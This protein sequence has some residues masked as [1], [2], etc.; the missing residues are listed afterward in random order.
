[1]SLGEGTEIGPFSFSILRI[2]IAAG[3]ARVIIRR[4]RIS[5]GLNVLDWLMMVW[6]GWVLASSIFHH[7]PSAALVFRL[8][9]VYNAFGIYFLLRVFCQSLDDVVGLCRVTAILLI[10]LAVEML[11]EQLT[12]NNLFS[13][14]GGVKETLS[15]RMGRSRAQGP[16]GHSILAGTV[17]AVSLPLMIGLWQ[18]RRKMAAAGIMACFVMVFTSLSSG[19]I[20]SALAA[21]GALLMWYYRHKMRLLRWFAVFG[22]IALDM[23]MEAKAYY[24]ISRINPAGGGG[25][26]RAR[27]IESAFKHLNEWWLAG[28]DYTR[29]WMPTGVPWTP[30][31]TDITNHYLKMGV[32]GGLPLMILYIAILAKGFSFVGQILR[33]PVSLPPK[34]QFLIWA[35]GA[36]LFAHTVTMIAVSYFDQSFIFMYLTIAAIGSAWSNLKINQKT[37]I[38]IGNED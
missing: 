2:L 30:D 1:M 24:I 19:P 13:G 26:H 11:Y 7:D 33:S 37:N 5:G 6:A 36:S 14:L 9:F 8:G 16:F 15:I 3:L 23:V 32:I 35:L 22:Y 31:H 27:L 29:H 4:E 10:P 38:K 28:T 12:G 18:F 25:W 21:I 20:M 17:G 34:S